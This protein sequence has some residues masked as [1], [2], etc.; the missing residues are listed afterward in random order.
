MNGYY[1]NLFICNNLFTNEN[2][3]GEDSVNVATGWMDPDG[4]P[5]HPMYMGTISVDTI[6]IRQQLF[7]DMIRPDSTADQTKI[8][9]NKMRIYVSNNIC[10]TD[11]LLNSYYRNYSNHWNNIGPY[12]LSYLNWSGFGTGPWPVV[13][14]PGIWANRRTMALFSA[15]RMNMVMTHNIF[16]KVDTKTPSI[17]NAGIVEL[18]GQWNQNQWNDPAWP[19]ATNALLMSSYVPGDKN[20]A[21]LP[22]FTNGV[23]DEN[24]LTSGV[25]KVSDFIENYDQTGPATPLNSTIDG[26]P[27]GALHWHDATVPGTSY[28]QILASYSKVI[29]G[30]SETEGAAESFR[31][32]Q[33]YPNPFNPA[34]TI[35]YVLPAPSH[36]MLAVYNTL[37]QLVNTLV[38]EMQGTGSHSV[39]LDGTG[40]AS[41]VYMYRI[42]AGRFVDTKKLVLLK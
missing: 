28:A 26:L 33:N 1:V 34:T 29:I 40:L 20:A 8:G 35:R 42:Q 2:W 7:A 4:S 25:A 39:R 5:G 12:P 24:G 6:T 37:G 21:T 19:V 32:E 22:G 41:G 36:V 9:L 13:N 30:I 23:K 14:I 27:I 18:M 16:T 15:Y 31:L 10:W 38:N 11:T 17:E 3:V